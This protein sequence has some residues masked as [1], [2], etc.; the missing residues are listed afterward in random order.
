MNLTIQHKRV[1]LRKVSSM[2]SDYVVPTH[3]IMTLEMYTQ[4]GDTF[5]FPLFPTI[6]VPIMDDVSATPNVSTVVYVRDTSNAYEY[7]RDHTFALSTINIG[8]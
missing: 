6:A 7:F 8:D 5:T 2:L 1:L 3:M 4:Y